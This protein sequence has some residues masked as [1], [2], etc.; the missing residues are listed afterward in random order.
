MAREV[1]C[2]IY[3]ITNLVNGKVYI[4]Q[5]QDIYNRWYDHKKDS[6]KKK[7]NIALYRAFN[8]YGIENFSFEII[9]KCSLEELDDKEIYYIMKYHSYIN[10]ED[11]NG[12]NMTIGGAL[13]HTHVGNDDQGKMVYQ[14]DIDGNFIAQ[15]RNQQKA[16]NSVGCKD[17]TA[18]KNALNRNGLCGGYQWRCEYFD[19]IEPF[20]KKYKRKKVYQYSINGD[21]IQE[22]E[23]TTEAS[24]YIGCTQSLIELCCEEKCKTGKNYR[25]SYSKQ[26]KLPSLPKIIQPSKWKVVEQYNKDG[27]F[28]QEFPCAKIASEQTNISLR[29]IQHCLAGETKTAY[30]YIFKYKKEGGENGCEKK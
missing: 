27:S 6:R 14:Y 18:I 22:F 2:G 8:K 1:I 10:L 25:W 24:L 17:S 29:S 21:F 12:Y 11:S 15:H 4:G 23:N 7:T 16:A 3:K 28:M 19:K 13:C 26:E 5:S 30:G 9:E 20:E